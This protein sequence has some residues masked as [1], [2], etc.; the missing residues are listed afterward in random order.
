MGAPGRSLPLAP[1]HRLSA[2]SVPNATPPAEN[3]RAHEVGPRDRGACSGA[4]SKVR[5]RTRNRRITG[6]FAIVTPPA[7]PR[8]EVDLAGASLRSQYTTASQNSRPR[9][10]DSYHAGEAL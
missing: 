10:Y 5:P 9:G 8:G 1:S 7:L 3:T 4:G 2:L 6:G